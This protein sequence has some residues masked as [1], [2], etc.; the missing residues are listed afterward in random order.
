MHQNPPRTGDEIVIYYLLE[1][2][3][4]NWPLEF[5]RGWWNWFIAG[6]GALLAVFSAVI[7]IGMLV[8]RIQEAVG[9]R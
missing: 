7:V 8:V 9:R 2:L 3:D 6:F 5:R 1:N 4:R